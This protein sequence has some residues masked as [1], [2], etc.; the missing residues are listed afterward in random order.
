MSVGDTIIRGSFFY[1]FINSYTSYIFTFY[2]LW[3]YHYY[4][5]LWQIFVGV[6]NAKSCD[7]FGVTRSTERSVASPC[8]FSC[9]KE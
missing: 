2:I 5:V 7:R 8:L 6:V 9:L 4:F 3:I 1:N